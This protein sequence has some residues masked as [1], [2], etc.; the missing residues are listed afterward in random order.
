MLL[1]GCN[2][3]EPWTKSNDYLLRSG[4]LTLSVADFSEELELKKAAYPYTIEEDTEGYNILVMQLINQLC[5]EMVLQRAAS[6]LG[7]TLSEEAL[8]AAEKNIRADYPGDVFETILL[9]NAV[10]YSFWKRRLG[11]SLTIELLVEKELKKKIE[12]TPYTMARYYTAYKDS[13]EENGKGVAAHPMNEVHLVDRLRL[14]KATEN[15][16]EW[17]EGLR[18]QYPVEIN[19]EKL[20]RLLKRIE[21][22]TKEEKRS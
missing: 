20:A 6:A 21:P 3:G 16:P 22:I 2:S 4:N 7:I 17:I 18:R 1:G 9:E 15:Y 12:I 5:E 14:E 13:Q 10:S 11:L 19:R 8:A